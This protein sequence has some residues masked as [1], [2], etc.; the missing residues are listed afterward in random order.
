MPRN[1]SI[2]QNPSISKAWEKIESSTCC[3]EA[4]HLKFLL[5]TY[6]LS[7]TQRTSITQRGT[8]LLKEVTQL[9]QKGSL[10][11]TLMKRYPLKTQEGVALMC[12]AEALLRIP[13][14]VNAKS[15]LK[16]KMADASWGKDLSDPSVRFPL[17]TAATFGLKLSS[18][19]LNPQ[20]S[21][22]LGA[23]QELLKRTAEPIV[24]QATLHMME[25]LAEKFV[26]G[27]TIEDALKRS[28]K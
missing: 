1:N 27:E 9:S 23:I 13:D 5:S 18:A 6:T 12:L 21:G 19:L 3:D 4:D 20:Q 2:N 24:Y 28:E 16:E 11:D 22:I 7:K 25:K 26:A 8:N 10:I 15:L 14:K 17:T